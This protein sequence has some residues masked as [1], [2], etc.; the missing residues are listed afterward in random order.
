MM[1]TIDELDDVEGI[2]DV[3]ARTIKEGLK[4]IQEQVFIDRHI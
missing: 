3:R 1:A 2:G 4:R